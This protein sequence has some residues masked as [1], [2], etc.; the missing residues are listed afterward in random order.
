MS[1]VMELKMVEVTYCD[2]C[3]KDAWKNGR[4]VHGWGD[5]HICSGYFYG[6]PRPAD[7]NDLRCLTKFHQDIGR[8]SGDIDLA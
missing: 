4:N 8:A 7:K 3:G 1:K 2:V 5:R 6:G